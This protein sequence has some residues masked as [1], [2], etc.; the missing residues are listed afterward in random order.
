ML[1]W[2]CTNMQAL[3]VFTNMM[4]R[5][6]WY[7]IAPVL[8]GVCSFAGYNNCATLILI[9]VHFGHQAQV[10]ELQHNCKHPANSSSCA[11]PIKY[12][13]IIFEDWNLL[14]RTGFQGWFP[15]VAGT[16]LVCHPKQRR[17]VC[18]VPSTNVVPIVQCQVV[19]FG[20]IVYT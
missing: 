6:R 16:V 2:T 4:E 17:Y 9:G 14:N 8:A 19:L 7:A 11:M 1:Y 12:L 13:L 3:T 18:H 5:L 15:M 10:G 20:H